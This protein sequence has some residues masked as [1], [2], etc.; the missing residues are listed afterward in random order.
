M[1]GS[2]HKDRQDR[3]KVT[4]L[5]EDKAYLYEV[6]KMSAIFFI[7]VLL[8]AQTPLQQL[9]KV[10]V[11]IEHYKEHKANNGDIS[12]LDYIRLHYFSGNHKDA[13]YDRD[14]QLPFRAKDVDLV[15]SIVLVPE[16]YKV[17]LLPPMYREISYPLLNITRLSPSH[18]YGIWQP[19]R[20]G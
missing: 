1:K 12:F 2:I 8:L 13:D 6:R 4:F 20:V 9:L 18:T 7:V 10:P 15:S 11:L 3:I 16:D 19:P 5:R 14:M 17:D